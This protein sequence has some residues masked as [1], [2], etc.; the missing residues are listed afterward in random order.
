MNCKGVISLTLLLAIVCFQL[1]YAVVV[2]IPDPNLEALIRE[3]IG[4][5]E[6]DITDTDLQGITELVGSSRD[7]ENL[8]GL[9]YCTNLTYLFL[10][11][12]QISDISSLANLTSLTSLVLSTNQI[13]DISS[14]ANLT[15]LTWLL[16]ESNQISDISSLA[17]LTSLTKLDLYKNQI[18]DISSLANLTSLTWLGL[19]SN[20]ISDISSLAN[21][22]SLT[23]LLLH[24][25]QISDISSLA[26]LTSLT[27]LGLSTNQI[28]DISSLANLTSLTDL[29]LSYNQ[30]S[31]I[32]SLA[33]LTS[34]TRLSLFNNQISD[35]SSLANLTSLIML[36]LHSNQISDISSLANLT[37]L[38]HL[39]LE[40]NQ[41]SDISSLANLTS[42]AE[43]HLESNQISNISS[44]ANA[45]LTSLTYLYLSSNQ[46]SDIS[47]LANLTSLTKL[48]LF[49]N[50]ISDIQPLVDNSGID[51]G[52]RVD[53]YS[54]PLN[55]NSQKTLIPTLEGRGVDVN[56]YAK[57]TI[58]QD[59]AGPPTWSYTLTRQAG[60]IYNWFYEGGG[61]TGASVTGAAA[62]AG[63]TVEFTPT[64]VTF[65][66]DTQLTSGSVS[67][68][69]ITGSQ[70]GTGSW[71]S[72]RGSGLIEGP[73]YTIGDVSGD[74][75]VT[76]YDA[77]LVLKYI[78]GLTELSVEQKQV[79]D[80]TDDG[81]ITAL[82]AALI[83]QY[84]VGLITE[85]P[86]QGAPMLTVIDENQLLTKIIG[87]LENISL[88]KEQK[89][90]L[91]QL[92][93]QI[94]PKQTVLLPNYP[95]PFNPETW[96]PFK[97]VDDSPVTI[98]IYNAKGQ[99]IRTIA[100][101]NR[102]AGIYTTKA[103]SAYWDGRSSN[104][105]K[106]ASGVYFY[107]L[108]AGDFSATRR[109]VIVK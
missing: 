26:N 99:L 54:N 78:V 22:T 53:L 5:P 96:L 72:G 66:N 64:L 38:I 31:D 44:L 95:N 30:I 25:N 75:I 1:A 76:A 6:G 2:D 80:V 56:Y 55:Y 91:E 104:G 24:S 67:G 42:L 57:G 79:A 18:S 4:K 46:I 81:T 28:S 23:W 98:Q 15:S 39:R 61:I 51:S 70:G 85:F 88:T 19:H 84:S 49:T 93:R 109:M 29:S 10:T 86:N 32:S 41:I 60:F 73:A 3:T 45:N 108:Q 63:W 34:L 82:D 89:H 33:N 62:T 107:R 16:L 71:L 50:Q 12:N 102:N 103:K 9:E 100:L 106:V 69:E 68:F 65:S 97:L 77:S 90:V 14:L 7:I 20:Q 37:S 43:L 35:I 101:G 27:E 40:S 48:S 74:G 21:L 92:R 36:Y 11:R 94:K 58:T 52:D 83:L 17:N 87:E 47:S 59:S 105:E 8:T 13:S